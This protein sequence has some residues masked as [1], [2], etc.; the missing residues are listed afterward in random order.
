MSAALKKRAARIE[1]LLMDVDGTMTA[2]GV[3]LLSQ[4]EEVALEI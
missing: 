3:T 1:V 4:T 2:G